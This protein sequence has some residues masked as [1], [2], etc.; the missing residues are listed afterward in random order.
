MSLQ[1]ISCS[2]KNFFESKGPT[3]YCLSGEWGVGK[4]YL[5]NEICNDFLK[6]NPSNFN[7]I[8]L[9]KNN[10]IKIS[11]FGV[12]SVDDLKHKIIAEKLENFEAINLVSKTL[13][14]S[15]NHAKL[16]VPFVDFDQ[17]KILES[18][19]FNK[20]SND[21]LICFDDIERKSP[22]LRIIDFLGFVS[23]LKEKYNCR[24]FLILNNHI[25]DDENKNDYKK[26]FEKVVDHHIKFISNPR[27]ALKIALEKHSFDEGIKNLLIKKIEFLNITNIRIIDKIL[28]HSRLLLDRLN[29]AIKTK[30][31]EETIDH[32]LI[33]LCLF[34]DG[35]YSLSNLNNEDKPAIKDILNPENKI[36][37]NKKQQ[38]F[39]WNLGYIETE[40]F[41][42]KICEFIK[43]GF[44]DSNFD[45]IANEYNKKFEIGTK[46][47]KYNESWRVGFHGSLKD[48]GDEVVGEIYRTFIDGIELMTIRNL[49][50]AYSLLN[51]YGWNDKANEIKN[52]Y[53]E[54]HKNDKEKFNLHEIYEADNQ[55]MK[56]FCKDSLQKIKLNNRPNIEIAVE[57]FLKNKS[58]PDNN[59]YLRQL[60]EEEFYKFFKD[61]KSKIDNHNKLYL[62]KHFDNAKSTLEKIGKESK[63]NKL[64]IEY[65]SGGFKIKP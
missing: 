5:F 20:F 57:N 11:L 12:S 29:Q 60:S 40:L 44:F 17:K 48:N 30:I 15:L 28:T 43:N 65:P 8:K 50:P 58:N 41:Q 4:T 56:N 13:K 25:L 7:Y 47:Y 42:I 9:P 16:K 26:Y 39:L 52:L 18:L 49:S 10:L 33:A 61:E 2:I 31:E 46:Q 35:F 22:S 34:C 27:D 62:A 59:D 53:Y 21:L 45:Q 54:K 55:E 1:E 19:F 64:R 23:M 37:N 14:Y 24:I 36:Y 51:E 3:I 6:K 38:N 32:A 63:I